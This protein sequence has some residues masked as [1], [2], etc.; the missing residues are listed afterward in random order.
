LRA[1]WKTYFLSVAS[2][3]TGKRFTNTSNTRY[4]PAY[5]LTDL[6]LGMSFPFKNMKHTSFSVQLNVNNLFD[7]DYQAIAWQPM[8][9]RNMEIQ[10]KYNFK[11]K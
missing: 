1:E 8:P 10:L 6:L 4:M 3:F 7:I 2:H 11:N 9:G 5:Q